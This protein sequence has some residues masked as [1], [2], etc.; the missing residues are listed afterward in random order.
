MFLYTFCLRN[1]TLLLDFW[2][3][4]LASLL[5][6]GARGRVKTVRINQTGQTRVMLL[7]AISWQQSSRF[8][9]NSKE[10]SC[11]QIFSQKQVLIELEQG[12]ALCIVGLL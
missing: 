7:K 4:S 9:L 8:A 10:F 3:F 5:L 2:V 1:P 11:T 12:G 6:W